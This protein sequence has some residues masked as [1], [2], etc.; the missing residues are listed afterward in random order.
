MKDLY[1]YSHIKPV[2]EVNQIPYNTKA[3]QK[4]S[5]CSNS[6]NGVVIVGDLDKRMGIGQRDPRAEVWRSSIK[7]QAIA[8]A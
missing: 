2:P 6:Q 4:P 8:V 7:S 3:R 5:V 1:G